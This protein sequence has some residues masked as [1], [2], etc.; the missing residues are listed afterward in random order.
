M[1]FR[2]P[3]WLREVAQ[4]FDAENEHWYQEVWLPLIKKRNTFREVEL[5]LPPLSQITIQNA[6]GELKSYL[7]RQ[8][9]ERLISLSF[10]NGWIRLS[11][12]AK[13]NVMNIY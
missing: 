13:I 11:F 2:L 3:L 9:G 10:M 6:L 5:G 8:Q 12:K 1:S 7:M 4:N